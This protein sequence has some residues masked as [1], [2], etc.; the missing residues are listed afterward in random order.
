MSTAASQQVTAP[1]ANARLAWLL[2]SERQEST[3]LA[4][5]DFKA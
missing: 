1:T 3:L 2:R 4:H 5:R